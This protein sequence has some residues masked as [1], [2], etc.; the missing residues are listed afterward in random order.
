MSGHIVLGGLDLAGTGK[1]VIVL[2][3]EDQEVAY[4]DS[5]GRIFVLVCP[6]TQE[7]VELPCRAVM[8]S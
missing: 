3:D 1:S 4:V 6:A 5:E 8:T 2:D 7:Y